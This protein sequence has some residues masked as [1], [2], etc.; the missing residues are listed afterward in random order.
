MSTPGIPVLQGGEDVNLWTGVWMDR[1][2]SG[3]TR[4]ITTSVLWMAKES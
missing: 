1:W 2:I 4:G 3:G